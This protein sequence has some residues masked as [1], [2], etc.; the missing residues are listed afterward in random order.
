MKKHFLF[1]TLIMCVAFIMFGV[2]LNNTVKATSQPP[3]TTEIKEIT[4]ILS[5]YHGR[6][7]LFESENPVPVK[8]FDVFTSSLPESDI[9]LIK[10]GINVKYE[11]VNKTLED[12]LS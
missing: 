6:I 9:E 2:S 10:G 12:Y 4:Y 8:V 5:D 3:V 11:D 1:I 7:A